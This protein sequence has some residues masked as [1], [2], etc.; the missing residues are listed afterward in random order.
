MCHG[1]GFDLYRY[2]FTS[3]LTYTMTTA[4]WDWNR[5]AAPSDL[6][7]PP[8]R[9]TRQS[10][11]GTVRTLNECDYDPNELGN[12]PHPREVF[13]F[14]ARPIWTTGSQGPNVSSLLSTSLGM[15][16]VRLVTWSR[17]PPRAWCQ[18]HDLSWST[19]ERNGREV[20]AVRRD[21]DD[22]EP[23]RKRNSASKP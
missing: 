18:S 5:T 12:T 17:K 20:V 16:R 4:V 1:I 6:A 15:F 8:P 22:L 13:Q 11:R 14:I 10:Y 19:A 2:T 3:M 21:G 23:G 7:P 9:E